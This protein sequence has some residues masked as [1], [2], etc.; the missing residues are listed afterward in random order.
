[1]LKFI[2]IWGE[3]SI[4]NMQE[5]CKQNKDVFSKLSSQIEASG[6][7]KKTGTQCSSKIKMLR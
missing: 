4:Q 7:K 5:G 1:M 2:D 3:E 6:F